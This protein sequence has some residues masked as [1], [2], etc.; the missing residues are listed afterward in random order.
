MIRP[1]AAAALA[2]CALALPLRAQVG[3]G[4]LDPNVAT[5]AELAALPGMTPALVRSLVAARPFASATAFDA[6]LAGS[7]SAE[8][9][10]ALY[11]K[12]FV[13][14]DLNRATPAEIM[15]VPGM[16]P[17]MRHEFEEYRPYRTLAQFRKEIGKYVKPD[18][19]ARLEGYVFVPMDL[20]TASDDDLRTIPGLGPRML[21]EFKEYRPYNGMERFRK[22]IGKYVKPAEVERL[23]RFVTVP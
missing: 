13:H 19:L 3:K 16:G 1:L 9:R 20:N 6:F 23:A 4:L 10:T 14:L 8:Q 2:A 7:L 11:G 12:A 15:L 21:R 5:E 17:R 18:E 22:E